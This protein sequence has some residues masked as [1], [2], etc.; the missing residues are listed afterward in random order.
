MQSFPPVGEGNII[1]PQT[2]EAFIEDVV[3]F[4]V[5]PS[6]LLMFLVY[7]YFRQINQNRQIRNKIIHTELE[8]PPPLF[9]NNNETKIKSIKNKQTTTTADKNSEDKKKIGLFEFIIIDA[10]V[11]LILCFV[12]IY[13]E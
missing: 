7:F 11:F 4:C 2:V 3:L 1:S 10:I 9:E 6:F 12:F 5:M 8:I 13:F